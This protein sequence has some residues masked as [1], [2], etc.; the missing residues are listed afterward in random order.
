MSKSWSDKYTPKK[1]EDLMICNKNLQKIDEWIKQ[2]NDKKG[3]KL[4]LIQGPSGSGKSILAKLIL[5]HY[6]FDPII[7]DCNT[8][9][10][11][12]IDDLFKLSLTYKN[13][14]EMFNVKKKKGII[15]DNIKIDYS[16]KSSSNEIKTLI[17]I[18]KANRKGKNKIN[19]P[20]ICIENNFKTKTI[21]T[22]K[23]YSTLLNISTPSNY[24]LECIANK[25]FKKQK[26]KIDIDVKLLLLNYIDNDIRQLLNVLY[27]ISTDNKLTITSF[28][29]IK[30]AIKN[31]DPKYQLYTAADKFMNNNLTYS[32][33][34]VIYNT[35]QMILPLLV[36]DNFYKKTT[37]DTIS[38]LTN[39]SNI[40]IVQNKII[41]TQSYNLSYINQN[42]IYDINGLINKK[43]KRI[44]VTSS[45]LLNKCSEYY[46][47]RKKKS[48]DNYLLSE[49]TQEQ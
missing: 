23:K 41:K 38:I 6:K 28:D 39:I 16:S 19:S 12:K 22:L 4:L 48:I 44:E 26:I 9:I 37:D 42:S 36:F 5:K 27:Y 31:K 11:I 24:K 2:I 18:L 7:Y 3:I 25:I 49:L 13:V 40:D 8:Q 15:L 46:I 45:T 29:E 17:K 21:K 34:D 35:I 10:N 32:G 47:A 14:E 30:K 20:I 1:L 33:S 43:Q